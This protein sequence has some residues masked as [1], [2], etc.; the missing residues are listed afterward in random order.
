MKWRYKAT[1]SEEEEGAFPINLI[2]GSQNNENAWSYTQANI[3]TV[4]NK[5]FY[6]GDIDEA[7]VLD[8]NKTLVEMDLKLQNTVNALG[9]ED[10]KPVCHFH[11]S[12]LGGEVLPSL[13]VVDTIR[14]MTSKVYTYVDG[15]VASAGTLI[16]TCGDKRYMGKHAHFLIHQLSGGMYGKFSE[17]QDEIYNT[18]NLMK[19]LKSFYK[20]HSKIPMKK[21]DEL[22]KRDIW[23][24]PE[25]CLEYGLIDE[26]L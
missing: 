25:E 14:N 15:Q 2:V 24:S 7:S 6:Y 18:T 5:I 9:V 21:L 8:L 3:R 1:E 22:L 17:M 19:M 12:T 20:E 4:E 10:M 23:L 13:A 11:L 16:S 26:I